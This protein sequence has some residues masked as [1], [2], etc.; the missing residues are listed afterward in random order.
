MGVGRG[1][2]RSAARAGRWNF[3]RR[4]E[5]W[6]IKVQPRH[7]HVHTFVYYVITFASYY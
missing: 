7:K 2:V 4:R 6:K 5:K 3:G 1:S